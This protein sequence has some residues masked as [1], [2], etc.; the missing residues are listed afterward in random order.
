METSI[1][2]HPAHPYTRS[3]IISCILDGA[4][5]IV[6]PSPLTLLG[7]L[8]H[9]CVYA[10]G[11]RSFWLRFIMPSG[12]EF[13]Y[14]HCNFNFTAYFVADPSLSPQPRCPKAH[15]QL[16]EHKF[17]NIHMYSMWKERWIAV[18][19]VCAEVARG[20]A[21]GGGWWFWRYSNPNPKTIH[22]EPNQ[23]EAHLMPHFIY[24]RSVFFI[25][26][27]F[28]SFFFHYEISMVAVKI[29]IST[30]TIQSRNVSNCYSINKP[31][32]ELSENIKQISHVYQTT[33]CRAVSVSLIL[34]SIL[35][36]N[37]IWISQ[38]TSITVLC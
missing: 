22:T 4:L 20:S 13:V 6:K 3:S 12:T 29:N 5:I 14:K 36:P 24:M 30:W 21:W 9:V 17:I 28:F 35:V 31:K 7:L 26:F 16:R 27:H 23:T 19:T 1:I 34:I 11:R 18:C 37:Q 15:P 2:G 10:I 33:N 8:G 38:S 32:R 25:C